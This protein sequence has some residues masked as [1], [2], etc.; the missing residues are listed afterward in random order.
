[1]AITTLMCLY[2]CDGAGKPG[3]TSSILDSSAPSP[4]P[5]KEIASS[6]LAL[7]PSLDGDEKLSLGVKVSS[8]EEMFQEL[9]PKNHTVP[10]TLPQGLSPDD[11]AA[12]G[13]EVGDTTAGFG[14]ISSGQRVVAAIVRESV[15]DR[16][17]ADAIVTGYTRKV[18]SVT[19]HKYDLGDNTYT[20]WE[21]GQTLLMILES[22]GKKDSV[23]LTLALG[24]KPVME[25]LR[26][27]PIHAQIDGRKVGTD[28]GAKGASSRS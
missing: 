27:D 8:V 28:T 5:P 3:G 21:D 19:P 6:A 2:G 11:Y 4:A 12:N 15:K 22:P 25:Y 16:D 23:Q 9:K 17:E 24:Y 20:F 13:W 7:Y 10:T 1:M 14:L 18:S 26:A